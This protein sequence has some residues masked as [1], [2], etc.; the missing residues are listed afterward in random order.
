MSKR[1]VPVTS[2][3]ALPNVLRAP[4]LS[5]RVDVSRLER[6]P[7]ANALLRVSVSSA[8]PAPPLDPGLT[9]QRDASV[10]ISKSDRRARGLAMPARHYRISFIAND[11]L[12]EKLVQLAD[13]LSEEGDE[14]SVAELLELALDSLLGISSGA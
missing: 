14:P 11:R 5:G 6:A 8:N 9:A 3:P 7:A 10:D 13:L 2:Q 12:V 4:T 1:N